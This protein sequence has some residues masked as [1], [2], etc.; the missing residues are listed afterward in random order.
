MR[1]SPSLLLLMLF[2]LAPAKLQPMGAEYQQQQIW[3]HPH[4]CTKFAVPACECA[5][6][7]RPPRRTETGAGRLFAGA[8]VLTAARHLA[9]VASAAGTAHL[10]ASGSDQAKDQR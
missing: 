5:N 7:A 10:L 4:S 8:S 2:P 1:V 3:R 6:G 9:L